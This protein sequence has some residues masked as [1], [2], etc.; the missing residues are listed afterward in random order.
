MAVASSHLTAMA[1]HLLGLSL[2]PE[3]ITV[4]VVLQNGS[5]SPIT[6][7]EASEAYQA[8]LARFARQTLPERCVSSV[9]ALLINITEQLLTCLV[10]TGKPFSKP[11]P[12]VSKSLRGRPTFTSIA[13]AG[14]VQ[15]LPHALLDR[16]HP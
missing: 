7:I 9:S 3:L 15:M 1:Q 4:A 14:S 11:S 5:S 8:C 13:R 12:R 10:F 6:H 2:G 16:K